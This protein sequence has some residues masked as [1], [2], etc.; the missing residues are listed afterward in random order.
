M[1]RYQ[2]ES[3][4]EAERA[5]PILTAGAGKPMACARDACEWWHVNKNDDYSQCVIH[6]LADEL[7]NI[8]MGRAHA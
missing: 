4:K 7:T 8:V 2:M 3:C 5:C 1:Y 6:R